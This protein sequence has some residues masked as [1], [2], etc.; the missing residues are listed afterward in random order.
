MIFLI[1]SIQ[2][3][4]NINSGSSTDVVKNVYSE[5]KESENDNDKYECNSKSQPESSNN[6]EKKKLTLNFIKKVKMTQKDL[7]KNYIQY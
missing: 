3:G 5:K 6:T 4:E 1:E 7:G 2:R